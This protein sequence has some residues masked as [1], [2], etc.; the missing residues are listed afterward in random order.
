MKELVDST[1]LIMSAGPTLEFITS[2][3]VSDSLFLAIN[4]QIVIGDMEITQNRLSIS[5]LTASISIGLLAIIS[6]ISMALC[7]GTKGILPKSLATIAAMA[8]VVA[9]SPDVTAKIADLAHNSL[10]T[11]RQY[12]HTGKYKLCYS[13]SDGG[14]SFYIMEVREEDNSTCCQDA[15]KPCKINIKW[16]RPWTT[17]I[18]CHAFMVF[19]S[20]G[21]I[22]VLEILL[23]RSS[24]YQGIAEIS[25]NEHMQ[26][27]WMYVPAVAIFCLNSVFQEISFTNRIIQP[28]ATMHRS[29]STPLKSI[30]VDLVHRVAVSAMCNSFK[31]GMY[32]ATAAILATFLGAGLPIAASGLLRAHIAQSSVGMTAIKA[33]GFDPSMSLCTGNI[34]EDYLPIPTFI[35]YNNLSYP[36][37]TYGKYALPQISMEIDN[38]TLL[39]RIGTSTVN[40]SVQAEL[41]AV[42]G[43][44]NCSLMSEKDV[45]FS[46]VPGISGSY[47]HFKAKA[48]E[49]CPP[50]SGHLQDAYGTSFRTGKWMSAQQVFQSN[51]TRPSPNKINSSYHGELVFEPHCPLS[52]MLLAKGRYSHDMGDGSHIGTNK[53]PSITVEDVKYFQC[54]PHVDQE[55]VEVE[56]TL[57][58]FDI[59]RQNPPRPKAGTRTF[60]SEAELLNPGNFNAYFPE[61][62]VRYDSSSD[63]PKP[64]GIE[65]M[66]D[67]FFRAVLDGNGGLSRDQVFRNET[68]VID[69][70]LERIEEVYGVIIAQVYSEKR[71]FENRLDDPAS[72][73]NVTLIAAGT[74]RLLQDETSTRILQ[75]LL[76]AMVLC[77]LVSMIFTRSK[78]V[79]PQNPC[80]IAAVA[81]YLADSSILTKEVIPPGSELMNEKEL[82]EKGIL[83]HG[84]YSFGWW[85]EGE[86][87]RYGVDIGKAIVEE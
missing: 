56:F 76:G 40:A 69:V 14:E 7:V 78:N 46:I 19:L 15:P 50:V 36:R 37:W 29:P 59:S 70:I 32:G 71:R 49:G 12:W 16:W 44:A 4:D 62:F 8:T 25:K 54:S 9:R 1:F 34:H 35:L 63:S 83:E 82:R 10:S 22:I 72:T 47:L 28:Y 61:L 26:S 75:G 74:T 48:R 60:Y 68:G 85:G 81:A 38:H 87:R 2:Q 42:F 53:T 79:L 41:P 73:L 31:L 66:F 51:D 33:N 58:E 17:T 86:S 3:I 57:P 55:I 23:R 52:F 80:S 13:T 39:H 77:A 64:N 18:S 45:T 20:S 6:I 30:H 27:A 65:E 43:V 11:S 24:R 84:L 67:H 21:F 5:S